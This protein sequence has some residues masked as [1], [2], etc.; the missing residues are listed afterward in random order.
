MYFT[1][2]YEDRTLKLL[3]IIFSKGRAKRENDDRD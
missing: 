2:V 1:Y 3:R